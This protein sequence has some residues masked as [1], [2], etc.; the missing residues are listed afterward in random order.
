MPKRESRPVKLPMFTATCDGALK[1]VRAKG[2]EQAAKK[3]FRMNKNIHAAAGI[4]RVTNETN[5]TFE[6]VVADWC[7]NTESKFCPKDKAK[8]VWKTCK[9]QSQNNGN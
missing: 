3:I 6:F 8:N 5:D 1:Q 7:S 2:P 4:L 9:F